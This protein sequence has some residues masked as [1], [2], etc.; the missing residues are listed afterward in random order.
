MTNQ[1]AMVVLLRPLSDTSL[2]KELSPK[3]A[4]HTLAHNYNALMIKCVKPMIGG[5]DTSV[6]QIQLY[7]LEQL[8]VSREKS[9]QTDQSRL[10]TLFTLTFSL[11]EVE[12]ILLYLQILHKWL[13]DMLSKY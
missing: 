4:G 2:E 1:A 10:V 8:D 7:N 11:I 13:V 5:E 12:C 9:Y 6:L 3:N